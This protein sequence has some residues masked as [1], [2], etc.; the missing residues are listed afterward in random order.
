MLKIKRPTIIG[1]LLILLIFTGYL[2]YQFTQQALRKTSLDYQRH[3]ANE[4]TNYL[5]A[6]NQ[7]NDKE[8]MEIVSSDDN[9]AEVISSGNDILREELEKEVVNL[10][11]NYFVEHRL[12]R[13]KLRANLIDRLTDIIDNEQTNESMRTDAQ[14]EIITIGKMSEGEL[15]IEG[16]IK[17]KGFDEALV[18]LTDSDIKVIVSVD[19]LTETEMVKI[20]DIVRS[21]TEFDTDDIKIIKKK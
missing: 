16:L 3:E 21:E 19:E 5:N 2:N 8:N 14:K 9:I 7:S 20:L 12:S 1:L 15:R 11:R 6:L 17:S 4:M 10:N 18:L 13:D